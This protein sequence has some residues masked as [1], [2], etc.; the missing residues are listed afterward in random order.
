MSKGILRKF[1]N[2]K[3][4]R[5]TS[6]LYLKSKN[7]LCERCG[8]PAEI[9]HHKKYLNEFNYGNYDISLNFENLESLCM[10]CHNIEHFGKNYENEG[11]RQVIFDKSGNIEKII[12]T[13]PLVKNIKEG[14]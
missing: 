13:T 5:K 10:T 1:Y 3:Q 2:S 12:E 6:N 7:F 9:C 8:A 11:N 4:W 14:Y